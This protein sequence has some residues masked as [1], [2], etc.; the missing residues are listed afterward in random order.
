M[1]YNFLKLIQYM[2]NTFHNVYNHKIP[3]RY[4]N[5]NIMDS[6]RVR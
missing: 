2:R 4:L 3:I 1:I 6:K 5:R